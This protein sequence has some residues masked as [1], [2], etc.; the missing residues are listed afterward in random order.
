[1]DKDIRETL[2]TIIKDIFSIYC[3]KGRP[4]VNLEGMEEY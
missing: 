1:M 3:N 4:M 2:K